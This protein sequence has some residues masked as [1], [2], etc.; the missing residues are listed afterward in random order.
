MASIHHGQS[1]NFP[2]ASAYA[3]VHYTQYLPYKRSTLSQQ[4]FNEAASDMDCVGNPSPM[5]GVDYSQWSHGHRSGSFAEFSSGRNGLNSPSYQAS[6]EPGE[7][8]FSS[9]GSLARP[10]SPHHGYS[11]PGIEENLKTDRASPSTVYSSYSSPS[12]SV[13]PRS[14]AYL[15]PN[16][17]DVGAKTWRPEYLQ[18]TKGQSLENFGMVVLQDGL[19]KT[20][21]YSQQEWNDLWTNGRGSTNNWAAAQVAPATVSPKALTLNVPPGPFSSS[22]SSQGGVLSL[23]DSNTD[24]GS[25]DDQYDFSGPEA[26]SAVEP[27]QPVRQL[28]HLLPDSIPGPKRG[29]P[30]VPS[31]GPA[32]RSKKRPL[33]PKSEH[34]DEAEYDQS[35]W[36]VTSTTDISPSKGTER[37]PTKTLAPKMIDLI[38]AGPSVRQSCPESAKA[39]PGMEHRDAQDEFLVKSKLAGM[40]YKD[41]RRQG[42]FT[43]AES[44]LRGRFRTLTKH[45]TARVRKPE[46]CENDVMFLVPRLFKHCLTHA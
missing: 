22:G 38:P 44:T 12:T 15:L 36:S 24:S 17:S 18:S 37:T 2:K 34:N 25:G 23:S 31:N 8:S 35:F 21:T 13:D 43:E 41:I 33:K 29:V 39:L 16:A 1:T 9:V 27:P 7:T 19:P 4:T 20:Y 45:K 5:L 40:S 6:N 10:Q 32:R 26:L 11:R 30:V 42:N 46:W 28:R 3:E 14:L